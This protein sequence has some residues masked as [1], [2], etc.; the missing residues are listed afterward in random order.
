M[1][2]YA[3]LLLLTAGL[4]IAGCKRE[5]TPPPRAEK[6]DPA[7]D[8]PASTVN[9]YVDP[10]LAADQTEISAEISRRKVVPAL[11]GELPPSATTAPATTRP[12]STTAPASE[13][14]PAASQPTPLPDAAPPAPAPAAPAAPAAPPAPD[15]AGG[16]APAP[17]PGT[18]TG[19]FDLPRT[20]PAPAPAAPA[21]P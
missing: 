17:A 20:A 5:D 6:Y 2:K 19:E 21:E 18:G 1:M 3:T 16:A 15:A 8:T 11:A 10:G 4:L 7:K 9:D 12:A 13:P 14:V